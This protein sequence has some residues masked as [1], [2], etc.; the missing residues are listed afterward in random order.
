MPFLTEEAKLALL[1]E[2]K[3]F[4]DPADVKTIDAYLRRPRG[5]SCSPNEHVTISAADASNPYSVFVEFVP[6]VPRQR[7]E[8]GYFDPWDRISERFLWRHLHREKCIK[9][10]F[11]LKP[12][13][14]DSVD[15]THSD[16]S[17]PDSWVSGSDNIVFL[18]NAPKPFPAMPRVIQDD[19]NLFASE[20]AEALEAMIS[21]MFYECHAV[22]GQM[23]ECVNQ[24]REQL[25]NSPIGKADVDRSDCDRV[26]WLGRWLEY[27]SWD[28]RPD[29]L[30]CVLSKL[31]GF[32]NHGGLIPVILGDEEVVTVVDLRN[33]ELACELRDDAA[34]KRSVHMAAARKCSP[35]KACRRKRKPRKPAA[36]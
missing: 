1:A 5:Y 24:I 17:G 26:R 21:A 9:G 11:R 20:A 22:A 8:V 23:A 34:W 13:T 35:S 27:S 25:V 19:F 7:G 30:E 36:S 16:L 18:M 6:P 33:F 28:S 3:G 15:G 2:L 31:D 29:V 10:A 4:N 12:R 32:R 14:R